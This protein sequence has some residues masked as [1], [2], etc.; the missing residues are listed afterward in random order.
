MSLLSYYILFGLCA[1]LYF[2]AIGWYVTKYGTGDRAKKAAKAWADLSIAEKLII[3]VIW[4]I[5][6]VIFI[7]AII[8][9]SLK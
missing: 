9:A 6:I 2:E 1:S 3:L 7:V 8:K 4:P 5:S